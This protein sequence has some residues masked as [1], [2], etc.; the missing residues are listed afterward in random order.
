MVQMI[1]DILEANG[2]EIKHHFAAGT[3]IKETLIPAGVTLTQHV[4]SYDHSSVLVSGVA[5]VEVNGVAI[6]YDKPQILTIKAGKN[7]KVTAITDVLWLCIHATDDKNPDTV[8]VSLM[9]KIVKE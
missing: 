7:H 6:T 8:D 4:H 2:V 5:I 1:K 9:S 3:Y